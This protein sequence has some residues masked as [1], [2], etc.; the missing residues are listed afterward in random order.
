MVLFGFV[1]GVRAVN[2]NWYPSDAAGGLRDG[3]RVHICYTQTTTDDNQRSWQGPY[4]DVLK[5]TG[6]TGRFGGR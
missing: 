2:V 4:T 5:F 6:S 1:A 3:T